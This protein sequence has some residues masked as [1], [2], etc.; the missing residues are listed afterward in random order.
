MLC[1]RYTSISWNIKLISII[2]IGY[3]YSTRRLYSHS[4]LYWISPCIPP[5]C[6]IK[7]KWRWKIIVNCPNWS[8]NTSW[9]KRILIKIKFLSISTTPCPIKVCR[10]ITSRS[11]IIGKIKS[12]T[13]ISD[14]SSICF[15]IYFK[16]MR[17]LKCSCW[18]YV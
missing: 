10:Y 11:I 3:T 17:T 5:S 9:T 14:R 1:S 8:R 13:S 6:C 4:F 15:R 18:L 2:C 16:Y 12:K 7:Y